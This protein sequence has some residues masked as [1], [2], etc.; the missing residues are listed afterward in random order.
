MYSH[1]GN[2]DIMGIVVH[3]GHAFV[4]IAVMTNWR[5]TGEQRESDLF[6]VDEKNG[7]VDLSPTFANFVIPITE[8]DK[9]N[10]GE[11][12]RMYPEILV[13]LDRKVFVS[14]FFDVALETNVPK[15]WIGAYKDIWTHVPKHLLQYFPDPPR[16][17]IV[18]PPRRPTIWSL[19]KGRLHLPWM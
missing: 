10:V 12:D 5:L 11:N 4:A 1:T 14:C 17:D 7:D 15:G 6:L 3:G 18:Y 2:W 13:D 19:L 9:H 8:V 16:W